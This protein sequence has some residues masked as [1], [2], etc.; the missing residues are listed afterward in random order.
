MARTKTFQICYEGDL[1]V[2]FANVIR[3]LGA[4]PNFDN[5]WLLQ[6]HERRH[7][8][9][10]LRHLRRHIAADGRLLVARSHMSRSRD[11]M[12]VRHSIT[13][14]MD[15]AKLHD[16]L[17]RLGTVL[18]LPFRSTFVVESNDRRESR[19]IGEELSA[20]C[21]D[22]ALIV[23]GISHDLAFCDWVTSSMFVPRLSVS[24]G[25]HFRTF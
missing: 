21:P 16:A 22:D 7:A 19:W 11:F 15:Y 24:E 25:P 1:T 8:V 9:V 10:L 13:A 23:T 6:V 4:E 2:E 20:F 12:L 18:E 14:G 3:R 17:G 5:S